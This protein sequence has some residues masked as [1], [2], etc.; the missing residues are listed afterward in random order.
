MSS[1][2]NFRLR[3]TNANMKLGILGKLE[4]EVTP[5]GEG[6]NVYSLLHLLVTL[7]GES[8]LSKVKF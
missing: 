4:H 2:E 5:H 8:L 6:Y 1:Q 7:C 3:K